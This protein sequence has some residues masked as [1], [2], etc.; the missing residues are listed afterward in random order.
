MTDEDT[1]PPMK[2]VSSHSFGQNTTRNT[3]TIVIGHNP[4]TKKYVTS[5]LHVTSGNWIDFTSD[6]DL[7]V[8][9]KIETIQKDLFNFA[10]SLEGRGIHVEQYTQSEQDAHQTS[11]AELRAK[12]FSLTESLLGENGR[13][14]IDFINTHKIERLKAT[15]LEPLTDAPWNLLC[16]DQNK[17][18]YLGDLVHVGL[19]QKPIRRKVPV[20]SFDEDRS[21][22]IAF[23]EYNGLNSAQVSGRSFEQR[24]ALE[25]AWLIEQ[26]FGQHMI[27]RLPNLPTK[28]NLT[29]EEAAPLRSWLCTN[30][31][32][33]HFNCHLT[34]HPEPSEYSYRVYFSQDAVVSHS[35]MTPETT[36]GLSA[37]FLNMCN[38]AISPGKNTVCL[39]GQF[40][41]WGA[42][43]VCGTTGPIADAFGR[44]FTE[45]LYK[46]LTNGPGELREAVMT[47]R[48]NLRK[49]TGCP[50][51]LLYIFAGWDDFQVFTKDAA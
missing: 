37:V 44:A 28:D 47:A 3:A 17:D 35:N 10:R 7:Y 14:L 9:K 6:F 8:D 29:R 38:S 26:H 20:D 32:L 22:T 33:Y 51:S 18:E 25:E 5:V 50:S 41:I 40:L 19:A 30:A 36:L 43:A 39:A 16:F 15:E 23:A 34:S 13:E 2:I 4:K 1:T 12:L 21:P 27:N 24:S 45:E 11:V 31:D 49:R 46:A 42:G 48:K